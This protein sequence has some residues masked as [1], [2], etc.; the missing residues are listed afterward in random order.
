MARKTKQTAASKT[1]AQPTTPTVTEQFETAGNAVLE[2]TGLFRDNQPNGH[3]PAPAADGFRPKK[4]PCPITRAGF[5]AGAKPVVVTIG[6]I[7]LTAEVKEFS[8][9][10]LGWYLN[11][12]TVLDVGGTPVSVQ[13]GVNITIVNSKELPVDG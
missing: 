8:T 9:G 1:E 11:G 5:R 6:G 3:A 4:T 12:K 10:S 2:A 7:P 13:C